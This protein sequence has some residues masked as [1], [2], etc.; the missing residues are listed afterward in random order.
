MF[1][2]TNVPSAPVR[3]NLLVPGDRHLDR[4]H[5]QLFI[6][7]D[8]L[9]LEDAALLGLHKLPRTGPGERL[10]K[11]ALQTLDFLLILSSVASILGSVKKLWSDSYSHNETPEARRLYHRPGR[12]PARRVSRRDHRRYFLNQASV[13]RS[14]SSWWLGIIVPWD[15]P[16]R[17]SLD[18][19][20]RRLDGPEELH[21]LL[22]G[23]ALVFF[24]LGEEQR[25]LDV[26]PHK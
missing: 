25:R 23:D 21:G 1:W 12:D 5:G 16:G 13:F 26:L 9:S 3:A 18:G 6:R 14:L 4:R 2:M 24:V 10:T 15:S 20:P 7:I 22:N 8:D 19:S 11:R 17:R